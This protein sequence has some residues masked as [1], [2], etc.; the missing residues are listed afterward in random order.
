MEE[1]INAKIIYLE[2]MLDKFERLNKVT[3]DKYR[4]RST[5][6]CD[7]LDILESIID[8]KSNDNWNEAYA[9]DLKESIR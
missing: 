1:R 8:N 4:Y 6:I 9:E 3:N 5:A 7:E 2:K